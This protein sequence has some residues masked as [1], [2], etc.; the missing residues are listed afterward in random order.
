M[1]N[2]GE[3]DLDAIDGGLV[4]LFA[5][6]QGVPSD[7]TRSVIRRIQ[8]QRWRREVFLGRMLYGGLCA[9]GILI[10]AG[11]AVAFGAVATLDSDMAMRIG[12]VGLATAAITTWPHLR[13]SEP[14]R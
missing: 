9:S 11:L 5:E 8:D 13:R 10:I 2:G 14:P 6:D 4:R 7:F 12:L 3:R 1:V